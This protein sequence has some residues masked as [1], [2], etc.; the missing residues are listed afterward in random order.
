MRTALS[1]MILTVLFAL[2]GC[3]NYKELNELSIVLGLGID[4]LPNKDMYEVTYQVVNPSEN[5]AKST[6]SGT[7][8]VIDFKTTGKTLSEAAMNHANVFSRRNIHSHIQLVVIGEKLARKESLNFVFDIFERD[9]N[10]RVNIPVLVARNSDVKTLLD[11]LVSIDKIPVRT[12]EGKLE[13]ASLIL[14]EHGDTKIYDV[15]E[16]LTNLGSE[17]AIS[18]VTIVGNKKTGITKKNLESMDK[19]YV[20][21]NGI[22]VFKEGMLVGWMDG[23]KTKSLQIIDNKIKKTFLRIPCDEKHYNALV[24]NRLRSHSHVDITKNQ[25]EINVQVQ[26]YGFISELLCNK[27]IS[28]REVLQEYEDKAVLELEKEIKEGIRAAQKMKSDVF[29]F[30][31]ILHYSHPRKWNDYSEQWDEVF[32]K[33]KVTVHASIDIEGV[34]MRIKPYPY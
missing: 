19:T 18:G 16:D 27:D 21:L 33:A 26:G 1:C 24:I 17:P 29:G 32:S 9:A 6:G 2:T 22:G 20:A 31:E 5:A 8:P 34:G 28:K 25:A 14:G 30:G 3:S 12:L 23:Q 10:V 11:T 4:Y 15:I 13:N 7:T